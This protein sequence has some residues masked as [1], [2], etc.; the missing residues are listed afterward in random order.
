[1]DSPSVTP[2]ALVDPPILS[3]RNNNHELA[4]AQYT[5]NLGGGFVSHRDEA[6][7]DL[8]TLS[9]PLSV[10]LI[11]TPPRNT[12]RLPVFQ[13]I[14]SASCPDAP[15]RPGPR[16]RNL[17]ARGVRPV[18]LPLSPPRQPVVLVHTNNSAFN[19]NNN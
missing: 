17:A 2:F 11:T 4:K 19:N 7:A 16:S 15:V 10:S 3:S 9:C 14:A 5:N 18:P 8:P 1:M 12:T 6:L 13:Q